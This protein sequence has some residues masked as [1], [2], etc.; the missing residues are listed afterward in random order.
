MTI[1]VYAFDKSRAR[2]NGRRIRE[3]TLFLYALLGGSPASLYAMS[4]FR[5][6]TKKYSFQLPLYLII[7]LQIIL[8]VWIL[9]RFSII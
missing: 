9:K 5:H 6:K 2:I 1:A 3:R 4:K 8:V 7:L